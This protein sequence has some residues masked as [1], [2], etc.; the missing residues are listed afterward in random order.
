MSKRRKH[1]SLLRNQMKRR[2]A[3]GIWE[4]MEGGIHWSIP[5]LLAMVGLPNTPENE[6]HVRAMMV[7]LV[8]KHAPEQIIIHRA[9]PD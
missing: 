7:E 4:D 1:A 3:P 2:I 8:R 6:Q 9:K 5:E